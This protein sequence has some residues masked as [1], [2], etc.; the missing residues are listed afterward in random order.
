MLAFDHQPVQFQ[1]ISGSVWLL[2]AECCLGP[3]EAETHLL[4]TFEG[5]WGWDRVLSLHWL[6]VLSQGNHIRCF[7]IH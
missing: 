3:G 2:Q 7:P 4:S 5:F 6:L 1:S